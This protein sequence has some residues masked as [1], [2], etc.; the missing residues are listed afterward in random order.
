MLTKMEKFET[1]KPQKVLSENGPSGAGEVI[2]NCGHQYTHDLSH[3]MEEY[4][5]FV[6]PICPECKIVPSSNTR[7]CDL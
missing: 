7:R 6:M 3:N 2:C 4:M 5:G 1:K